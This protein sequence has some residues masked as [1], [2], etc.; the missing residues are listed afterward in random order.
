M[1]LTNAQWLK[2]IIRH[3]QYYAQCLAGHSISQCNWNKALFEQLMLKDELITLRRPENFT[4][5]L[6]QNSEIAV[7]DVKLLALPT[8]PTM[9]ITI[10][11]NTQCVS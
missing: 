7:A 4:A 3:L 11:I 8:I 2:Q 10:I 6:E 5:R 1:H 9:K